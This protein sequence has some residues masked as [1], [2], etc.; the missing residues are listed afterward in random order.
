MRSFPCST[1]G[2]YPVSNHGLENAWM[3][4]VA[5]PSS[6]DS[7]LIFTMTLKS[8]S[9]SKRAHFFRGVREYVILP[10]PPFGAPI[11]RLRKP[12]FRNRDRAVFFP[13]EADNDGIPA[14]CGRLVMVWN[15]QPNNPVVMAVNRVLIM[16][17]EFF[18][19]FFVSLFA[20]MAARKGESDEKVSSCSC[21]RRRT[22]HCRM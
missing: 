18:R 15:D 10:I 5:T 2:K 3:P 14:I 20:A 13:L 22:F 7:A 6:W 19:G 17:A 8:P 12:L 11:Q 1:T 16:I 9:H 4:P 21:R